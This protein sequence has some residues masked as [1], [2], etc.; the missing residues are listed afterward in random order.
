MEDVIQDKLATLAKARLKLSTAQTDLKEQLK[1]QLG[2]TAFKTYEA[3]QA[4]LEERLKAALSAAQYK[5]YVDA[6]AKKE[7]DSQVLSEE[8]AALETEVKD[9][10]LKHG[11]AVKGET[12]H[13]VLN[14]GRTTIDQKIFFATLPTL[15]QKAQTILDAAI[16]TGEPT[17][18]IRTIKS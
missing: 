7:A 15:S 8:V 1:K 4:S 5:K 12:L 13:A 2:K 10:V 11:E 14:K 18:T 17:V 6:K 3:E 9:L 16:K